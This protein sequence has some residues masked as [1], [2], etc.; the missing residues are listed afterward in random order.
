MHKPQD[1]F[2]CTAA[3]KWDK[4]PHFMANVDVHFVS[5][6]QCQPHRCLLVYLRA[7]HYAVLIAD[8]KAV[9]STPLRNLYI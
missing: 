5:Y 1:G 7:Y 3:F 6:A 4:I 8:R 2:C 9:L